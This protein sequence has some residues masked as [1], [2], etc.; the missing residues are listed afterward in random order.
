M[1]LPSLPPATGLPRR[2]VYARAPRPQ[3][4]VTWLPDPLSSACQACAP[5]DALHQPVRPPYAKLRPL[6][7]RPASG[8]ERLTMQLLQAAEYDGE[9]VI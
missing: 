9:H 7:L 6:E 3:Q 8:I 2:L 5:Q 1:P 4:R